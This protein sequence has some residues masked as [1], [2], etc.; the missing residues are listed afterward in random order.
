[1]VLEKL[2]EA[3]ASQYRNTGTSNA[4]KETALLL[5]SS[6]H[7]GIKPKESDVLQ[8]KCYHHLKANILDSAQMNTTKASVML[9]LSF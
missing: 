1:M 9:T 7:G 4:F 2:L 5:G 8:V 3:T 6:V